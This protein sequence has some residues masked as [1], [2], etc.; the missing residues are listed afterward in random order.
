MSF[1]GGGST[2]LVLNTG[3]GGTA[4]SGTTVNQSGNPLDTTLQPVPLPAALP[5]LLPGLGGLGLIANR[6]RRAA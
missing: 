4:T 2:G 6:R 1:T 5:L 3:F